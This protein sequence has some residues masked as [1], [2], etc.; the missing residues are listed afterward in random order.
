MKLPVV[1]CALL[2]LGAGPSPAQAA[3]TVATWNLGWHLSLAQA[4]AWIADCGRHY[5]FDAAANA[6]S[7][8]TDTAAKSGWELDWRP[9]DE[10]TRLPW[11]LDRQPPCNVYQDVAHRTVAATDES[12]RRRARQVGAIVAALDSP[13]VIALQEVS[14]EAAVREVLGPAA[15][16][17]DVCS[18]DGYAVQRLAFAWRKKLSGT[19]GRCEVHAPLSLPGGGERRPRPG[20][21][22]A[23]E[24]NGK[25][26][27]F[28][29][30]H[31]KSSCVSPL[32]R[33][34]GGRGQLDGPQRDCRT[35]QRQVAPLEA[36][37]EDAAERHDRIVVLGDFNRDLWHEIEAGRKLAPRTDGSDPTT[38][39]PPGA[40]V[41]L[42]EA[43]VNDGEP[44][45]SA[46][47]LAAPRCAKTAD[48]EALCEAA[49]R[50]RL[51]AAESKKLRRDLGC[52]NPVGLDQILVSR[53]WPALP[54]PLVSEKMAIA[55]YGGSRGPTA[56]DPGAKTYL[57][58]SDHCPVRLALPDP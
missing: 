26:V 34:A 54:S 8:S 47:A 10:A 45:A 22:L 11:T 17:Y 18:Y 23:L 58:V 36:W 35:L 19:K 39:L 46:L 43:E 21:L 5:A 2:L 9:P 30:V 12:Y 44:P 16:E 28:L 50:A 33:D 13:D 32:E 40:R 14:G 55:P 29:N 3:L 27:A 31:L 42:L 56:R 48:A 7:A 20:L 6:W 53:G 4:S 15:A 24:V 38:P 1:L 25:S 37:I 41:R 57:A 49:K 52:R 51:S